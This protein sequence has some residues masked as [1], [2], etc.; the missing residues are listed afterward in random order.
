MEEQHP[1]RGDDRGRDER[2]GAVGEPRARAA[3]QRAR[4]RPRRA[5]RRARS[6][7]SP[8]PEVRDHPGE[9]EVQRRAAALAEHGAEAAR[10]ASPRPTKSASVSSSCGGQAV[11]RSDEKE[12]R[13]D[14]SG[15]RRRARNRARR[16]SSALA[17]R[18]CQRRL[19]FERL[20]H[21]LPA[22]LAASLC[23]RADL[24]VPLSERAHL[25][26]VPADHDA[27]AG[28]VRGLRR[29]R[30]SRSCCIPVAVHF[31]GSGFYSTDYGTRRRARRRSKDGDASAATAAAKTG[32]RAKKDAKPAGDAPKKAAG[33]ARQPAA[34][35]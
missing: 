11:S 10:R 34:S 19:G 2:D 33:G 9:E 23:Y 13:R 8:P 21:G 4:S 32:R 12:R 1:A 25:R 29:R 28:S 5:P 7:T 31:K 22:I 20:R 17:A 14:A 15:R 3:R 18:E 26:G 35:D 27:A 30:P 24:R 6:S 16:A